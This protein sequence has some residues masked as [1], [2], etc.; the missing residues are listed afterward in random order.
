MPSRCGATLEFLALERAFE[1]P[2]G[3]DERFRSPFGMAKGGGVYGYQS[4]TRKKA[5]TWA[6]GEYSDGQLNCLKRG[7]LKVKLQSFNCT[8]VSTTDIRAGL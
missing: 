1:F 6:R 2:F 5:V 4:G 7:R 8:T 3:E